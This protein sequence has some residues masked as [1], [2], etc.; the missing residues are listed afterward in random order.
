MGTQDDHISAGAIA[1][2]DGDT[3]DRADELIDVLSGRL[4]CW[5]CKYDLSGLSVTSVCPECA[6]PVRTTLLAVVDPAAASFAP[7]R[8]PKLA[9]VGLVFWTGAAL[10]AVLSIWLCRITDAL[11]L[12]FAVP[13]GLGFLGVLVPIFAGLSGLGS[14]VLIHPQRG[15]TFAQTVGPALATVLYVPLVWMLYLLH[16]RL[17]I[18]AGSPY[19][20]AALRGAERTQLRCGIGIVLI[21]IAFFQRPSVREFAKRSV[22]MRTGQLTR[23]TMLAIIAALSIALAGD[24]VLT[25]AMAWNVQESVL[26]STISLVLIAIG[27]GLVT[28]GVV[29]IFWDTIR[30]FPIIRTGPRSL[31]EMIQSEPGDA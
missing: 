23:Q 2:P 24:L 5:V 9:A 17:D 21:L 11:E 4:P 1:Q 8:M 31:G 20:T 12:W 27:S 3:V 29:G 25:A 22:L 14:V 28:A 7:L 16:G 26:V 30:L 18:M 19:F 10:I 15:A 13:I 6:T